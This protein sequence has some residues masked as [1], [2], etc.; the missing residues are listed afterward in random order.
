VF[1]DLR[2]ELKLFQGQE[3]SQA[4]S[5][6]PDLSGWPHSPCGEALEQDRQEAQE[7]REEAY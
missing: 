3:S 5:T 6:C 2:L 1:L 7:P 4:T